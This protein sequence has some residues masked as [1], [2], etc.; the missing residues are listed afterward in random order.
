MCCFVFEC[1]VGEQCLFLSETPRN[2]TKH[3]ETLQNTTKHYETLRNTTNHYDQVGK[4]IVV[5][6]HR[7]LESKFML[8]TAED[9]IFNGVT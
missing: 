3:Y 9:S 4:I 8:E 7:N 6:V 5:A 2:T 1:S